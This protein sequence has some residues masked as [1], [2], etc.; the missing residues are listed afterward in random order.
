VGKRPFQ[1]L[2]P[3]RAEAMHVGASAREFAGEINLYTFRSAYKA[4][5]CPLR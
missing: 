3:T 2:F 1:A 4:E 5:Q